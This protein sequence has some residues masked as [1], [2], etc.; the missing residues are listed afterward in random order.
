MYLSM[1]KVFIYTMQPDYITYNERRRRQY[2]KAHALKQ[3]LHM[4]KEN[5]V[6]DNTE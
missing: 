3:D 4:D 5:V 2:S 1:R 6:E